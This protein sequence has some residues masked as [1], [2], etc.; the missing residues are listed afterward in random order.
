M[1]M[2]DLYSGLAVRSSILPAV[3]TATANGNAVDLAGV[4]S[5]AFVVAVGAIAGAAVFGVK[6]QESDDGATWGDV[7]AAY[8]QSDAPAVLAQFYTYRLGYLGGKRYVRPVAVYASG[9]SAV[10]GAVAL[11][12]PLVRPVL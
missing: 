12:E 4:K 3:L 5:V 6:L 9:T 11:V 10:I 2:R 1:L 7:A 8:V